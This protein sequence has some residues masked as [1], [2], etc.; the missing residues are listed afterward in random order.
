[1]KISYFP[2]FYPD[3]LIYS[4][5]SRY[6]DHLQLPFHRSVSI[7]FFN[8]KASGATLDFPFGLQYL[9]DR[10]PDGHIYTDEMLINQ[11]T[12]YPV[13]APFLR[14]HQSQF[15]REQMKWDGRRIFTAAGLAHS[16]VSR[17]RWLRYCPLC[18]KEEREQLEQLSRK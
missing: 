6:I 4:A 1:M 14:A 11:H 12:L 13:Y 18:V 9:I 2:D 3:E 17:P 5:A 15:I 7:H 10:L 8:K 16:K